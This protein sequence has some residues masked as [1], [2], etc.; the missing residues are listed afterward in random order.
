MT[1][2][3]P[4]K[5]ILDGDILVYRAAYWADVEGIDGLEDRLALDIKRWTPRGC[6]SVCIATSCSRDDNFRKL[7]WSLYKEHRNTQ[8]PP[9]SLKVVHEIM[10]DVHDHCYEREDFLEADDIIGMATSSYTHVGVS[11]DKDLVSTPGWHWNPDKQPE[12]VFVTVE[13]ADNKFLEQWITGDSTDNVW[14]LW[15]WGPVKAKKFL[16]SLKDYT[17]IDKEKAIMEEYLKEDW[18]KRPKDRVPTI[19]HFD[20]ALSQ[21]RCVRILRSGDFDLSSKALSL[22]KSPITEVLEIQN[23]M[24]AF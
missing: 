15:K 7:H 20:F 3:K 11:I 17:M 21:A 13:E 19:S 1:L 12:P 5:A 16:L 6:N 10:K 9:K 24:E 8:E 14:G 4:N 18:S 2:T 22:W 23:K